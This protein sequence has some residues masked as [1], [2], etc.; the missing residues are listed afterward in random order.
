LAPAD[1]AFLFYLRRRR[2]RQER[3]ER[4]IR[5]RLRLSLRQAAIQ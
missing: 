2:A 3:I 5:R 4:R 1:L